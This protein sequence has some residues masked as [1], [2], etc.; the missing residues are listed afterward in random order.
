VSRHHATFLQVKYNH[1]EQNE[2]FWIIDGDLKGNR[3]TNGLIV[4]GKRC[5]SHELQHGDQIT[6]ANLVTIK[7]YQID[8]Y[9]SINSEK[10]K[11]TLVNYHLEKLQDV[12]TAMT[13]QTVADEP[14]QEFFNKLNDYSK[15]IPHPT[16]EVNYDGKVVYANFMATLK[17]PFLEQLEVTHPI[18]LGLLDNLD[19][20][21]ENFLIR[22]I[23]VG[24]DIFEEYVQY[25]PKSKIIR[26]YVTVQ[27]ITKK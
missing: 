10:S 24:L 2:V 12:S 27:G 20:Q 17:L 14:A 25:L 21:Q 15:F 7:Y 26:I 22:A 6:L 18:L 19:E 16:L 9:H 11:D 1:L 23:E 4:N 13:A 3:S 5:L 8:N